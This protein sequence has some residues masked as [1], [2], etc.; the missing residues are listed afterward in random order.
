MKMTNKSILEIEVHK[1]TSDF[2]DKFA[3]IIGN[4]DIQLLNSA[5]SLAASEGIQFLKL[6]T[7]KDNHIAQNIY[8]QHG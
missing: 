6:E 7:A 5:I 8:Q 3:K 2:V 1:L 4:A